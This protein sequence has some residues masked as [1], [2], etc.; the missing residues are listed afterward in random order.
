MTKLG[1]ILLATFVA[2]GIPGCI[3][4]FAPRLDTSPAQALCDPTRMD[5]PIPE[6]VFRCLQAAYTFRDTTVYA[7]LLHESF[8]FIYRDYVEGV[9]ITWGRDEELRTTFG[10]FQNAQR[11]DLI[12]NNI[13][14]TSMD[15]TTVNVVRGFNLT[16][17]F[18]PSD[19]SYLYGYANLT[20]T[21]TGT[22]A[23]WKIIRW[24]D[25][26]NY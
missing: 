22:T 13:L 2:I 5:G 21:R 24:R 7:P 17:T 8:T 26:S 18:N 6:G 14:S 23:P 12:W 19:V 11:L 9:D 20:F 16:V 1:S 3:N 15:S 4:P 25:E 10:L